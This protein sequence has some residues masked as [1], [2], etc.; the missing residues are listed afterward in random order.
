MAMGMGQG[1]GGPG[2]E[3]LSNMDK[4]SSMQNMD[5]SMMESALNMMRGMDDESLASMMLSSGMVR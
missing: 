4:L 3:G 2:L 1:A 5:P